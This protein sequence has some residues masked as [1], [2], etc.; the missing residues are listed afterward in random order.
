MTGPHDDDRP[1]LDPPQRV[2]GMRVPDADTW[3]L[4]GR[5]DGLDAP[6][7]DAWRQT[8]FVLG[9]DL[10]LVE[11]LKADSHFIQRRQV[12]AVGSNTPFVIGDAGASRHE[13]YDSVGKV[14]DL[15][16]TLRAL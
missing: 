2:S 3:R 12:T 4:P 5:P 16:A 9:A 6:A 8:G 7:E 14:Y 1:I 10:R 15:L 13:V 11:A